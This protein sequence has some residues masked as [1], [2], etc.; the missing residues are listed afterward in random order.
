[1]ARFKAYLALHSRDRPCAKNTKYWYKIDALVHL[2]N[3]TISKQLKISPDIMDTIDIVAIADTVGIVDDVEAI[4]NK[5]RLYKKTI[6]KT[7]L[8]Q[9]I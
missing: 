4:W 7:L 2:C 1:M 5:A 6:S 9:S 3:T 8:N